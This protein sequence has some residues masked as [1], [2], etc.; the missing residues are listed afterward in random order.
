[1][2]LN[3]RSFIGAGAVVAASL[4]APMVM[5]AGKPRV[6]V[7]LFLGF[8]AGLPLLLVF[9]TL[10]AWLAKIGISKTGIGFFSW[11]GITYSL[12][13]IWARSFLRSASFSRL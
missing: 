9:G 7:M 10:S 1:M 13:F 12:K 8:S 3:R 2:T 5:G 4:S 11:V 6:V